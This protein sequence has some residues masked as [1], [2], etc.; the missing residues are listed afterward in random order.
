MP[1]RL[2]RWP[3]CRAAAPRERA[4][5]APPAWEP[6]LCPVYRSSAPFW[7]SFQSSV[8]RS[9]CACCSCF[10]RFSAQSFSLLLASSHRNLWTSL[11]YRCSSC[12]DINLSASALMV[13]STLFVFQSASSFCASRSRRV[14][15][16]RR[17]SWVRSVRLSLIHSFIDLC[18]PHT[19]LLPGLLRAARGAERRFN[20]AYFAVDFCA[21]CV[22]SFES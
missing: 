11:E 22:Y 21:F 14:S 6:F 9:F 2:Q 3:G 20:V 18:V 16:A 15:A 17:A 4:A 5:A 1:H 12:F 13:L 7:V 8:W 19:G 10:F